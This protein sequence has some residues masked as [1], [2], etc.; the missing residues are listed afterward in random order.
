MHTRDI[1][2]ELLSQLGSS[3]EAREYLS[4]FNRSD[5]SRFAVIKVGGEIIQEDLTR[6]ASSLGFLYHV[7]L[8]PIVVHG[9]GAQLGRALKKAGI[10][11]VKRNGL[12]VTTPEMMSVIRPVVY[13]QNL[14]LVDALEHQGIRTRSLQHGVFECAYAD[15]ANLGLVGKVTQVDLE[16]VHSAIQAGAL[17]IVTCLGE[18]SGGQVVNVNADAA[19]VQLVLALKP[20]KVIFLTPTGG[21]LDESEQVIS[22]V[23]LETD[24]ERLSGSD[25]VH[26]GMSLKLKQ[27]RELLQQLPASSSVSITS[28]ANLTRELFTHRGAGTLVRRGEGF[29]EKRELTG[30]LT[31]ELTSLIETCF[32]CVLKPEYFERLELERVLMAAS[33]RAAAVVTRGGH[34]FAYMDKFAVT[35]DAQGEG[36]GAALWKQVRSRF[37]KLYWRSRCDNPVNGWYNQQSD[38]CIRQGKWRV[39]GYGAD[40]VATISALVADAAQRAECWQTLSPEWDEASACKEAV[41]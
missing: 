30:L 35:P 37:S 29:S 19:A 13:R 3:R 2:V 5:L 7:G 34:G 25:W 39:F 18:T 40:T 22:A 9:A 24:Y 10:E 6:L 31:A 11:S 12:R 17:P 28:A 8:F 33:G 1:I 36:V 21:L 16:G 20:C 15:E 32:R 27:I 4:K 26:S 38:F 23:N 41:G 14:K